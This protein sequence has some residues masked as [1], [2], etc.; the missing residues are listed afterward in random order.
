MCFLSACCQEA[1]KAG[2]GKQALAANTPAVS[3]PAWSWNKQ[4]TQQQMELTALHTCVHTC[5]HMPPQIPRFIPRC[6]YTSP[7]ASATVIGIEETSVLLAQERPRLFLLPLHP[8][9]R[10]VLTLSSRLPHAFLSVLVQMQVN[11]CACFSSVSLE[12][13]KHTNCVCES[14]DLCSGS[15]PWNSGT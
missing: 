14:V 5:N 12:A 15:F 9:T 6:Q 11:L 1:R 7:G 3:A 4:V 2:K 10:A 13:F 8:G